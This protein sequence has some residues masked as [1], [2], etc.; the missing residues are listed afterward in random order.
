MNLKIDERAKLREACEEYKQTDLAQINNNYF[1]E[2]PYWQE[3]LSA[4]NW[5]RG[6]S[7]IGHGLSVLIG[8]SCGYHLGTALFESFDLEIFAGITLGAIFGILLIVALAAVWEVIKHKFIHSFFKTWYQFKRAYTN[9]S[10]WSKLGILIGGSMVLSGYGGF[11]VVS[12]W[13]G[14]AETTQTTIVDINEKTKHLNETLA[15]QDST[16]ANWEKA[17]QKRV[18]NGEERMY[19]MDKAILSMGKEQT[20]T[21][22]K[23]DSTI[24]VWEKH[25]KDA[26]GA[27]LAGNVVVKAEHAGSKIWYAFLF[28]L[29]AVLADTITLY[30]IRYNE[31]YK[32]LS[33]LEMVGVEWFLQQQEKK[34]HKMQ[35]VHRSQTTTNQTT[36][37]PQETTPKPSKKKH[38]HIEAGQCFWENGKAFLWFKRDKDGALVKKTASELK[39]LRNKA[40][41]R[42]NKASSQEVK[43]N[44]LN[45]QAF[46]NDLYQTLIAFQNKAEAV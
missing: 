24:Q 22:A 29:F 8:S 14:D 42:A 26:N 34:N 44:N 19:K 6:V 4:N 32:Y 1:E 20:K 21:S 17:Q 39:G 16:L 2:K 33:H 15:R 36:E 28:A 18:A 41:G 43:E 10:A 46:Y 35:V 38:N 31:K 27:T 13:F 30:C 45:K 3:H 25:N 23:L 11:E 9:F 5:A 12:R 7:F 40:S 37:K